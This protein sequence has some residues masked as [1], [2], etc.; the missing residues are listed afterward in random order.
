MAIEGI[1]IQRQENGLISQPFDF[2]VS[3]RRITFTTVLAVTP[4]LAA[5][6]LFHEGF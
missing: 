2:S 4:S 6:L 5:R 1:T 3:S